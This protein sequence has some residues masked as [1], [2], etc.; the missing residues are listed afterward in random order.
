MNKTSSDLKKFDINLKYKF[1][2]E[3]LVA[4]DEVG[5][6]AI[7]GPFVAACCIMNDDYYNKDIKDSK[8]LSFKKV[9]LLNSEIKQH[10]VFWN[11]QSFDNNQIDSLGIQKINILAFHNLR[12]SIKFDSVLHLIDGNI[13]Q[14]YNWCISVEHGDSKSFSIACASILAKFYRDSLLI[15]LSKEY[16]EYNLDKNKG[17]GKDYI[18]RVK[19]Y[20]MP[21]NIHRHSYN[22]KNNDTQIK[23]F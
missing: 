17:Y 10:A 20:G 15:E 6:G 11:T 1:Q 4:Y 18:D 19:K 16:P 5:R 8:Q 3:N 23:L 13:M 22:I 2:K 12:D 21:T 9:E 14:N 7:C